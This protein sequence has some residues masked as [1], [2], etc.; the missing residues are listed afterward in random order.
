MTT[1]RDDDKERRGP[2]LRES[3]SAAGPY[4]GLGLQ[5]ALSM[6]LFC[7]AGYALDVWL[8]TLPW[9][10]LAGAV[11]GFAAIILKLLRLNADLEA[12][13]ARRKK[14]EGEDAAER[15]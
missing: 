7:G 5:L 2:S 9:F 8:G 13:M 14:V 4:L 12:D 15:P 11:L 10:L 6:V 3:L 1:P